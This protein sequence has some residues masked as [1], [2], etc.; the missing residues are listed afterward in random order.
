MKQLC[1]G[2]LS[3]R[4]VEK[5][6]PIPWWVVG[7]NSNSL[8]PLLF[9]LLSL[10]AILHL[11]HHRR[12]KNFKVNLGMELG[13]YSAFIADA[14][15]SWNERALGWPAY[16][17][18]SNVLEWL[19]QKAREQ[20]KCKVVGLLAD[21]TLNLFFFKRTTFMLTN[22]HSIGKPLF[23]TLLLYFDL[24]YPF[25]NREWLLQRHGDFC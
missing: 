4:L 15:K 2:L 25:T 19:R 9:S 8:F 16:L 13:S 7:A 20:S 1:W 12:Q 6:M 17:K 5:A 14:A 21:L 18:V 22:R 11:A 10:F 23:W 3:W 24:A